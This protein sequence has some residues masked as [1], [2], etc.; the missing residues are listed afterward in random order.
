MYPRSKSFTVRESTV[1]TQVAK[2]YKQLSNEDLKSLRKNDPLAYYSLPG[3]RW[4]SSSSSNTSVGRASETPPTHECRRNAAW[5]DDNSSN[6]SEVT[7]STSD[8]CASSAT[9]GTSQTKISIELPPHPE[10]IACGTKIGDSFHAQLSYIDEGHVLKV[11]EKKMRRPACKDDEEGTSE[12]DDTRTDNH[13]V[14]PDRGD[15]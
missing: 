3:I 8:S 11:L 5:S 4:V 1:K 14:I 7:S 2:D 13:D 6:T 15:T 10:E 9:Q 12:V